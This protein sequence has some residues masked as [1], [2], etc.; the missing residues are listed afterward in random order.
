MRVRAQLRICARVQERACPQNICCTNTHV[1]VW[2][3]GNRPGVI[4]CN[5][6]EL[7]LVTL[8]RSDRRLPLLLL[9]QG[10]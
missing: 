4:T 8:N 3:G 6:G 5:R 10:Q 2:G 7:P 1:L 9:L